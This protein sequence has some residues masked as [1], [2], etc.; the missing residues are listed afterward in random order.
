MCVQVLGDTHDVI[1][2]LSVD[3][4]E[5]GSCRQEVAS[6]VEKVLCVSLYALPMHLDHDLTAIAAYQAGAVLAVGLGVFLA[7][8]ASL[9]PLALAVVS[10]SGIATYVFSVSF[11]ASSDLYGFIKFVCEMPLGLG[12]L[13]F[14][15]LCP[16]HM[17]SK[18]HWHFVQ[19]VNVAVVGNIAMMVLVP[20]GGTMRG[21]SSRVACV[22]LV[23]WLCK[24]MKAYRWITQPFPQGGQHGGKPMFIFTAS[25][26]GWVATHALYRAVM[27]TLPAF[28][29]PRYI[30]LEPL[31]LGVMIF[32]YRWYAP[33]P[34]T[35]PQNGSKP[36]QQLWGL[37]DFFGLADTL[38]VATMGTVSHIADG[39]LG[40][41]T[42]KMM[43]WNALKRS[44]DPNDL[45]V[46]LRWYDG[47][48]DV[49]GVIVHVAVTLVCL[50]RCVRC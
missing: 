6:T 4:W 46:W 45:V 20:D 1:C 40:N 36:R 30:L 23:L 48:V 5:R 31:S 47:V 32:C 18:Y 27:V 12:S 24:E 33:Y 22:G 44:W 49:V 17:R 13:V 35:N 9:V 25:P 19:Y 38:V 14:F 7:L 28:D 42:L 29:T 21:W 15:Q 16:L 39:A 26:L 2:L 3:Q 8:R 43:L 11:S 34:V 50:L 37:C 41:V 10:V